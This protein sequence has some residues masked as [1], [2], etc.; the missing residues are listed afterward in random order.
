MT[1]VTVVNSIKNKYPIHSSITSSGSENGTISDSGFNEEE[2]EVEKGNNAGE[3]TGNVDDIDVKTRQGTPPSK[4]A[5]NV[6][7][8]TI[9]EG[10]RKDDDDADDNENKQKEGAESETSIVDE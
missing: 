3:S 6:L 7:Q 5:R 8:T 9:P 2:A 1:K 4:E 10:E